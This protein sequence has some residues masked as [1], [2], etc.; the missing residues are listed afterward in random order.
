MSWVGFNDALISAVEVAA[1]AFVLRA[2]CESPIE[3][4]LGAQLCAM[5]G[6]LEVIPQFHLRGFRYDFAIRR[7]GQ[8]E[9]V[10]LIECDGREFHSTPEQIANDKR[11]DEVAV[12]AG[13][14][15]VR[16]TG[17]DI[18][19]DSRHCAGI[20]LAELERIGRRRA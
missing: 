6:D 16:F 5:G 10:V 13:M 1:H 2:Q 3:V 7:A 12:G 17:S 11:K 9:N 4:M 18:N 14:G 15:I 20:A 19:A 8:H